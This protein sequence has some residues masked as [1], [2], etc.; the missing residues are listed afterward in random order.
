MVRGFYHTYTLV[1]E[2]DAVGDAKIIEL[3]G[4][5]PFAAMNLAQRELPERE[6]ELLEDGHSLGR[7]KCTREGYWVVL[8]CRLASQHA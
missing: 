6:L 4:L 1:A 3:E 7:M 2:P 8:P 5:E